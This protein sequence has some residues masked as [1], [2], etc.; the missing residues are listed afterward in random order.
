MTSEQALAAYALR[1]GDNAL[2][3][4]QRLIELVAAGPE[5]EEEL[6]NANFALDYIGQA[7]MFYSYI[8]EL[9]GKGREFLSQVDEAVDQVVTAGQKMEDRA[10]EVRER[11]EECADQSTG[12]LES[13]RGVIESPSPRTRPPAGSEPASRQRSPSG[14]RPPPSWRRRRR[15][16]CS[17]PRRRPC[18]PP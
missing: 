4:G 16:P 18:R 15:C 5:L 14:S 9:E 11:T 6:A 13:A 12:F 3:L 8:A 10:R 2:I 17:N 7:R 1:L